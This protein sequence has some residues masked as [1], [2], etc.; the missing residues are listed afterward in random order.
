[1]VVV[2]IENRARKA[3]N[4]SGH[5]PC[6]DEVVPTYPELI[7]FSPL[8]RPLGRRVRHVIDR[9]RQNKLVRATQLSVSFSDDPLTRWGQE[10]APSLLHPL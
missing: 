1:M 9:S 2:V 5:R 4:E 6:Q 8:G 3:F 7:N 10:E